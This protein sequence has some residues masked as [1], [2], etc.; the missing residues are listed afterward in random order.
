MNMLYHF[1][2]CSQ[3]CKMS[4][5]ICECTFK[6]PVKLKCSRFTKVS[7]LG[8]YRASLTASVLQLLEN[9]T[10][11]WGGNSAIWFRCV[12][13]GTHLKLQDTGTQKLELRLLGLYAKHPLKTTRHANFFF[14][15]IGSIFVGGNLLFYSLL[16]NPSSVV[17]WPSITIHPRSCLAH[18]RLI[19]FRCA[20]HWRLHEPMVSSCVLRRQ[21]QALWWFSA[22][23]ALWPQPLSVVFW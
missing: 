11:Y 14:G 8:L 19:K 21:L 7:L 23:P 3:N 6:S 9:L 2:L 15:W 10:P 18:C 22:E 5:L 16:C 17:F 4:S 20:S 1:I 13:P 12:G